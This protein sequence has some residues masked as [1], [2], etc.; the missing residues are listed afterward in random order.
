LKAEDA[1]RYMPWVL[2]ALA[3]PAAAETADPPARDAKS[4]AALMEEARKHGGSETRLDKSSSY[5]FQQ[6]DGNFLTL[7]EWRAPLKRFVCVIAKDQKSTVCVNWET[8]RTTYGERADDA[9]PWK[10][11]AATPLEETQATT[12]AGGLLQK[13][14]DYWGETFAHIRW[15]YVRGTATH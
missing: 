10:T 11:R 15:I 5:V 8:G 4:W 7:T 2:L 14:A 3:I 1:M 12:P 13:M 9:S 6:Q